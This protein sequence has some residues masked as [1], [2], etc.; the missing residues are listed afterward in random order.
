MSSNGQVP[1]PEVPAKAR[2]RSWSATHKARILAE[3]ESLDKAGEGALLR[4]E[5]IYS[6]LISAWRLQ[7]DQGALQTLAKPA[8]RPQSDPADRERR[9]VPRPA[10]PPGI[11]PASTA[12]RAAPAPDG[13]PS[14]VY[15]PDGAGVVAE[16]Q[17]GRPTDLP[18]RPAAPRGA[19]PP[20]RP[21]KRGGRRIGERVSPPQV[22]RV[23][24]R[25][26]RLFQ[27]VTEAA[28][29]MNVYVITSRQ[30]Q[31]AIRA[32]HNDLPVSWRGPQRLRLFATS[33][34]PGEVDHCGAIDLCR[35]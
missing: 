26:S 3:Y 20:R 29:V 11:V 16:P 14:A 23:P 7:R 35:Y 31:P 8:G 30:P 2:T 21:S 10:G 27:G 1:D 4:R 24:E 28:N 6:S 5:G 22:Q 17:P 9:P 34:P 32:G 33:T 15:L 25:S 19:G 13:I 12:R 18:G